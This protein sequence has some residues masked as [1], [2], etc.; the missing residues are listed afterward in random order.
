MNDNLCGWLVF[1]CFDLNNNCFIELFV[2]KIDYDYII[3][4]VVKLDIN[5]LIKFF[6]V[7]YF[8]INNDNL[9]KELLIINFIG[10]IGDYFILFCN[11]NGL[12]E[13]EVFGDGNCLFCI[14]LKFFYGE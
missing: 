8:V 9:L 12:V 14:G 11:R 3:V 13:D 2:G 4:N 1:I 10:I 6:K 5:V 7:I